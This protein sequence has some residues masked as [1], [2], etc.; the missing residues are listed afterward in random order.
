MIVVLDWVL[1]LDHWI[2]LLEYRVIGLDCCILVLESRNGFLDWF[3]GRCSWM[4]TLLHWIIGLDYWCGFWGGITILGF[5]ILG[6]L[7]NWI[8]VYE[9]FDLDCWIVGLDYWIGL[10]D[11]AFKCGIRNLQ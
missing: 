1:G 5:G 2:E 8:T 11:K 10:S 4:I 3:L 6:S 9:S 7:D